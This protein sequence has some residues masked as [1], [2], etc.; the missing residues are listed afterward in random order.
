[1]IRTRWLC[2]VLASACGGDSGSTSAGT[3]TA[4]GQTGITGGSGATATDGAGSTGSAS[5]GL[6]SS[7]DASGTSSSSAGTGTST[8]ATTT[9]AGSTGE[10]DCAPGVGTEEVG[11]GAFRD[12]ATCLTWTK[13]VQAAGSAWPAIRQACEDLD[14]EGFTDWRMPTTAEAVSLPVAAFD[15]PY[16]DAALTSPRYVAPGTPPEQV[17]GTFHVCAVAW[18]NSMDATCLWWG[19]ANVNGTFCVRGGGVALPELPAACQTVCAEM[20]VWDAV[21]E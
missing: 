13:T 11:Q 14:L 9:G 20:D 2:V 5:T 7:T 3:E 17:E 16:W 4:T 21:V 18:F 12:N 10:A 6:G 8:G 15:E 1:M 19:P